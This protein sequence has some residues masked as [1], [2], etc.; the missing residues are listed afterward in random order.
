M[1]NQTPRKSRRS[2]S[3][4]PPPVT[5]SPVSA[6]L[7]SRVRKAT[8]G[9][10][11][12]SS[13]SATASEK[14]STSVQLKTKWEVT[15]VN[16]EPTSPLANTDTTPATPQVDTSN[17]NESPS[18]QKGK[19][20]A[21][22]TMMLGESPAVTT[23]PASKATSS[24]P[25]SPSP[26][27]KEGKQQQQKQ[28]PSTP[29]TTPQKKATN[30]PKTAGPKPTK[31][32][33]AKPRTPLTTGVNSHKGTTGTMPLSQ[34]RLAENEVS[35]HSDESDDEAPETISSNF[36]REAIMREKQR[37]EDAVNQERT[38]KL[39]TEAKKAHTLKIQNEKRLQRRAEKEAKRL[40]MEEQ[41]NAEDLALEAL[42]GT[43]EEVSGDNNTTS[44]PMDTESNSEPIVRGGLPLSILNAVAEESTLSLASAQD[45]KKRKITRF[46]DSE[47]DSDAEASFAL[48]KAF[49]FSRDD[50]EFDAKYQITG[51]KRQ[52][53]DSG[54]QSV[55][56]VLTQTTQRTVGDITVAKLDAPS[57]EPSHI[58]NAL[59]LKKLRDKKLKGHGERRKCNWLLFSLSY[60]ED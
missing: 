21:H 15:L 27:G 6:R 8:P 11:T 57:L 58:T 20:P 28:K 13:S 26:I 33:P 25:P 32:T 42:A 36:A 48:G 41:A 38:R 35:D 10:T 7:R 55:H 39:N 54:F 43:A 52:R 3:R 46:D 18:A 9:S 2:N 40:A 37:I 22:E 30:T 12:S 16:D 34:V 60:D 31:S 51:S 5:S 50:N 4:A 45:P 53:I 59:D 56:N 47:A 1:E 49:N 29:T 17:L 44:S 19:S 14:K 24:P 23:T